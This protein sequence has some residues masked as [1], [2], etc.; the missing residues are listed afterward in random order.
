MLFEIDRRSFYRKQVADGKTTELEKTSHPDVANNRYV[1]RIDITPDSVGHQL[2]V[3][4]T[5]HA[6]DNWKDASRGFPNCKFGFLVQGR[7]QIGLVQFN[8]QPR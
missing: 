3:G 7:D 4:S 1:V 8:H 5:W 2:L 6:L